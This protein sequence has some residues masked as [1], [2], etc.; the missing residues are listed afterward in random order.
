MFFKVSHQDVG[1]D[2]VILVSMNTFVHVRRKPGLPLNDDKFAY[3]EY[4]EGTDKS[5]ALGIPLPV[6]ILDLDLNCR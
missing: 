3:T 5:P 2:T 6:K 4:S 1:L